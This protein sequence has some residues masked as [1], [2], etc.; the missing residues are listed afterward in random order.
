MEV[1]EFGDSYKAPPEET[2]KGPASESSA[3]KKGMTVAITTEDMQKR[4][5][6][7]KARATLLLALPD[8]HHGKGEVHTASVP[9]ASIQV[10]TTSTDVAAASL[11]HDTIE[12]MDIKWNMAFL[13]MMADRFWKKTEY[14]APRSQDR[15]KRESYKQGPKEK[16][17]APKALMAING[18]GWDL[19]YMANGEENHALVA[20]DE[21]PT[22]FALMAKS[23]S[24]LDNE[25][26]IERVKKEK[27][28]LDNKL[29][30]FENV[31]KDLDNL[32]G[33]QKLDKNKE[34]LGYS[35][36]HPPPTQIYSPPKK[37]LSWTGL[38]EFV[39]DT[40]TNYRS[41]MSKP[42]IMFLKEADCP[43]VIKINNTENARKSTVKYAEMYRNISKA[44]NCGVWVDNEETWPKDNY[45]YKSMTPR[46]VLL[47]PGTTPIV[48]NRQNNIDDKDDRFSISPS[49]S[50][51][52]NKKK[53]VKDEELEREWFPA[54]SIRS[55][56][57]IA[58]DSPYLLV[59]ITETSQSKQHVDTSLIHLES[60]KP[61]T[62][63][64]FD[65]DSGR[66]YIHHCEY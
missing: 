62:T 37:D 29:T 66:I 39:D 11:S 22:E 5:N 36:V 51:Y 15:G 47:K 13:S 59:L 44:S 4:R 42:M 34:G 26:E 63:K 1:I 43:R 60:C 32:L 54:Q 52:E 64:L 18:I 50:T 55:S 16:E 56:N 57:A 61:P 46:A 25:N 21:V 28:S 14:R 12:E 40:V 19:S 31:S 38:P 6:D 10:S 7:V 20:N 2:G 35:A 3:K 8:E 53:K 27:E 23:S 9:T 17:P 65:N 58:L 45:T 30:G 33:S 49:L 41:I 48:G 24:S